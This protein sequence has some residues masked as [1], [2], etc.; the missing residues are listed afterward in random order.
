MDD[1]SRLICHSAFCL[2][3]TALDIEGVLKQAVMKRG[4]PKKLVVDNGSAYRA[5]S[6]QGICARLEIRLIYCRPYTPEGKAKLERWHRVV[7]DTFL[8]ELDTKQLKDLGDLNARLWAWIESEYHHKPHSSL[9]GLTP[10]LRWQKDFI[11]IKPL[12]S[13]SEKLDEIFYHRDTRKVRKDGTISYEGQWLEVPYELVGQ[14][15]VLVISPHEKKV[16]RVESASGEY[17]GAVTPLNPIANL[18]RGRARP[19]E[20]SDDAIESPK[21]FNMVELALENYEHSL[22]INAITE[23]DEE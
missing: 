17:L 11:Q 4:L 19:K 2:G 22:R 1:A 10:S 23:E 3:E 7:R 12:G 21:A 9:D 18:N 8:K 15:I 14:K 16:V 6:L 13:F 5:G 20:K